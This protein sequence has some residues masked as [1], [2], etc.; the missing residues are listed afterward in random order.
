MLPFHSYGNVK[1]CC[2][3]LDVSIRPHLNHALPV[4]SAHL[5]ALEKY[6]M[7]VLVHRL[8]LEARLAMAP[9]RTF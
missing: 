7:V 5:L 1:T 6:F 3:V 2:T 8:Q 4:P 9:V